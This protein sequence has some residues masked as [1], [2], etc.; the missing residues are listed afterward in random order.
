MS[1]QRFVDEIVHLG[2]R[3]GKWGRVRLCLET[4]PLMT[5]YRRGRVRFTVTVFDDHNLI[6]MYAGDDVTDVL[7]NAVDG[8][9]AYHAR[10]APGDSPCSTTDTDCD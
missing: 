4:T 3:V 2:D 8:I 9:R 6:G 10:A 7:M 1:F 5:S